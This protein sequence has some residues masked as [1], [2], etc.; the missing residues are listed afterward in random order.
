MSDPKRRVRVQIDPAEAERA[1]NLVGYYP[2]GVTRAQVIQWAVYQGL[3]VL[4]KQKGVAPPSD[5]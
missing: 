5:E 2:H 1:Q 4:E 3:L